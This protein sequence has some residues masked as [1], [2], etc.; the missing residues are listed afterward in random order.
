MN[1]NILT[2]GIRLDAEYKE[3]LKVLKKEMS[4]ANPQPILLTGLCEGAADATYASL[5]EDIRASGAKAPV[6]LIFPE[7]KEEVNQCTK[8]RL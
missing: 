7:E 8:T 3:L 4:H 1:N 6:L 2:E 5:I